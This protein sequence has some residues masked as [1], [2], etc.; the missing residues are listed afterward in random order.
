MKK[1][2][3]IY[4][5]IFLGII[6]SCTEDFNDINEQPDALSVNDVSAKFLITNV[7]K[8]LFRPTALPL[9]Y[10]QIFHSD[11]Y[12]GH[13]SGGHSQ[14][15]WD[16]NFGWNYFGALQEGTNNWLAEYNTK[17]TSY[18]NFVAPGGTLENDQYH[19]IGLIMKG[20]Y[21][22]LYTDQVG[23]I[24]YSESS[25]PDI[26]LPKYDDQIDIYKGII[27]E[28]NQAITTIGDNT[29]TGEG[30]DK[31]LENDV[32]F[33]GNMQNWKQLANSLKLRMALRA[34]GAVGED[35]AATAASEAISSGVLANSNALFTTYTDVV[36]IWTEHSHYGDI[37]H[38]FGAIGQWRS[39]EPLINEMSHYN[40]PRLSKVSNP[41]VGGT[42]KIDISANTADQISF[43]KS[44]I[45]KAGLVRDTDYTWTQTGNEL[46]ITMPENKHHVGLPLRLSPKVKNLFN[47]NLF[48]EPSDLITAKSNEGNTAFPFVV[49]SAAD[50]HFMVAEAIV[51]GLVSGDAA[52]HY[53]TG[54]EHAMKL[55]DT[56]LNSQ[57]SS[58]DM[59]TLSG[60]FEEKLE[61]IATQRWIANYTNGYEGWAIV[62]DT[63]YP[64]SAIT[65]SS[66]N[67][68]QAFSGVMNG[69]YAHRLRYAASTYT[70]NADNVQAAV[71]KQGPDTKNTKLW[72]AKK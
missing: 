21:Y 33:N 34:H 51:K 71:A 59:G 31:L 8:S 64:K 35:F 11:Q 54:L 25:N 67:D 23:M 63:G 30:V 15:N 4:T 17:I 19:A 41:S 6:M 44:T 62:R 24:P 32:I 45:D 66:N 37:W 27:S 60:T 18:L 2:I 47:G 10:G 48:S 53:Q 50:S 70:N 3:L 22:H 20:L 69:G 42:V 7:Q 12:A 39:G 26:K 55:W 14:Y 28:L 49:M 29:T 16:G 38:G 56:S 57:F 40:D 36:N 58:S 52:G 72:W 13:H 46:I 43:L 9:W 5:S 1:R 61:K 65:T 68:I